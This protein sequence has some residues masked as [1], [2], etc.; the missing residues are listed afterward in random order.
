MQANQLC[1]TI[2]IYSL[3]MPFSWVG[4][5]HVS[6]ERLKNSQPRLSTGRTQ[7]LQEKL[8]TKHN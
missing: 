5:A 3:H 4:A 7:I 1:C 2:L 6:L 8:Q